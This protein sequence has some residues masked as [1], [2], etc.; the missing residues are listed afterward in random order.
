MGV[1][2]PVHPSSASAVSRTAA[3]LAG[4]SGIFVPDGKN[5]VQACAPSCALPFALLNLVVGTCEQQDAHV[6]PSEGLRGPWGCVSRAQPCLFLAHLQVRPRRAGRLPPLK[7]ACP[8]L[9]CL[10]PHQVG[11]PPAPVPRR[12]MER[13][14]ATVSVRAPCTERHVGH[15]SRLRRAAGVAL[16]TPPPILL[17]SPSSHSMASQGACAP[18][19][20]CCRDSRL[21]PAGAVPLPRCVPWPPATAQPPR[22]GV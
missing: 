21:S 15:P 1:M 13:C 3:P 6:F 18:S 20:L 5:Y 4:D 19:P 11:K 10:C 9:L 7:T 2:V 8:S 12:G 22:D 16:P 14:Q 17:S